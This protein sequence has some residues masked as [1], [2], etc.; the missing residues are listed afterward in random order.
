MTATISY[1]VSKFQR[2]YPFRIDNVTLLVNGFHPVLIIGRPSQSDYERFNR[3]VLTGLVL[4]MVCDYKSDKNTKPGLP[5][6]KLPMLHALLLQYLAIVRKGYFAESRNDVFLGRMSPASKQA[7]DDLHNEIMAL[8]EPNT[9]ITFI[10]SIIF[11][12]GEK[13]VS[14]F[15]KLIHQH[16]PKA[17][18]YHFFA[19]QFSDLACNKEHSYRQPIVLQRMPQSRNTQ[20]TQAVNKSHLINARLS[21]KPKI[22]YIVGIYN[23]ESFLRECLQSICNQKLKDIEIICIDDCST[24]GSPGILSEFCRYD[25]R[26]KGFYNSSNIGRGPT[27]NFGIKQAKGDYLMFV[28]ADDILPV[29]SGYF[30]HEKARMTRSTVIQGGIL[31]FYPQS[32]LK[33]RISSIPPD[34][35]SI[36][37][38]EEAHLWIPWWFQSAIFKKKFIS[39]HR[40]FFPSLDDGEDPVFFA[41]IL[42]KAPSIS[43]ISDVVYCY[44]RHAGQARNNVDF[45]RHLLLVKSLFS[46]RCPS[47][48]EQ[49]YAHYVGLFDLPLRAMRTGKT[50]EDEEIKSWHRLIGIPY[51]V[52]GIP[53][54]L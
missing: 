34:R 19:N 50:I 29:N 51:I 44:R 43:T 24:D 21:Q 48:W 45:Y 18:K 26:V 52:R 8:A 35:T 53:L 47:A 7:W 22:S 27:R 36:V 13:L 42:S 11:L 54:Y 4:C 20:M 9:P 12:L 39:K 46:S 41:N 15:V 6:Y 14:K 10:K 3:A 30:L 17:L 49:G 40:I 28:D 2:G 25:S 23:K 38:R 33:F 16:A 32:K 5:I 31:D 1:V 37:L